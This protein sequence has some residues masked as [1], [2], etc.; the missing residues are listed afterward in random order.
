ME[1]CKLN[2]VDPFAYLTSIVN[3]AVNAEPGWRAAAWSRSHPHE[4][5]LAFNEIWWRLL[6]DAGTS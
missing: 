5:A 4:I 1:A 3:A 2:S 6:H